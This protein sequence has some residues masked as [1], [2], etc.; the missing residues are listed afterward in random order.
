MCFNKKVLFLGSTSD[1]NVIKLLS[2]CFGEKPTFQKKLKPHFKKKYIISE[3]NN[4]NK[5]N[6]IQSINI[7][8]TIKKQHHKE[9]K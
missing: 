7:L 6:N 9:L 1:T 2:C 5:N 3:P 8:K 4:N